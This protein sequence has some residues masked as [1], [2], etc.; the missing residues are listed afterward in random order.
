MKVTLYRIYPVESPFLTDPGAGW[1]GPA[2]AGHQD[3]AAV[4]Q[5]AADHLLD[6]VRHGGAPSAG[7]WSLADCPVLV[8]Q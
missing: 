8:V 6:D 7:P 2:A 3:V 5:D 1:R 4:F